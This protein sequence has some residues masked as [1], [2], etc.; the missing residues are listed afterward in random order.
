M[1]HQFA[2]IA[3]QDTDATLLLEALPGLLE[4]AGES[5]VAHMA[6][7]YYLIARGQS[8]PAMVAAGLRQVRASLISSE[9]D[10]TQDA[11][12]AD[13][14]YKLC[15]QALE[16]DTIPAITDL[17]PILQGLQI[18]DRPIILS[19]LMDALLD[20]I[21]AG[22]SLSAYE[23]VDASSDRLAYLAAS[24]EQLSQANRRFLLLGAADRPIVQV[25]VERWLTIAT[26]RMSDLQTQ[27]HIVC[28][29]VTR[30]ARE[31]DPIRLVLRLRNIGRATALNVR[32]SLTDST[33]YMGLNSGVTVDRLVVG[34]ETDVALSLRLQSMGIQKQFRAQ[35]IIHYD[36][37]R[38]SDQAERFADTVRIIAWQGRFEFIPNPYVVGTP[39]Q[40]GS[41][42]FFGRDDLF[43][44]IHESLSAAQRNNM[45]LIGQRRTGKS[46]L[47]K[48]L[49][50]RLG[51]EVVPI[52]LDGQG[53]ALDPGLSAFFFNVAMEMTYAL[54]DR[55]F[56][57]EVPE[58]DNFADVPAHV[59]ERQFLRQVRQAIGNR[60]L[61]LLLDEF[62]ELEVAVLRGSLDSS[63]FGYL[64]HLMQHGDNVSVIF[65]GTH[66][67]EELSADYWN[68]L[69]NISLYKQVGF[70][71]YLEAMRLIHEPVASYHMDYDDLAVDKMWRITAG[72]PYFL[73]LLCHS[74]VNVHNR[75]ERSYM[76]V[77]DVNT[78]LDDILST[79][80]AHFLHM[81]AES[82]PDERVLLAALSRMMPLTGYVTPAQAS[83][84]LAERG[85]HMS[86]QV[87]GQALRHLALRD[88]LF[89][90][91]SS[92]E[93]D[94][95]G[96]Y[97]WR[98]GLLG[99][100][101]ERYTSL[102]RVLEEKAK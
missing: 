11:V 93:I 41:P 101:V 18:Q 51:D 75:S 99:L 47:L 73:Q 46:S 7:A 42:L 92:D 61:L 67:L 57:I 86:R 79:G 49:P 29:L 84:Y 56:S 100:W 19:D 14:L 95:A 66:R 2:Q 63:V 85:V 20:L 25:I 12:E 54:E 55:G 6:E 36:D 37:P 80:E 34:E 82:T 39:L 15:Q 71:T 10:M 94:P 17:L 97:G 59:F 38:G 30:H 3:E 72:H 28:E 40:A 52:Y 96:A 4:L 43:A 81:W 70:L 45:V 23:R 48:Q 76:T 91:T 90:R 35:F 102:S 64:R 27:A 26:S 87:L 60:H 9:T 13:R 88:I 50:L 98:L 32:I 78:A 24:I 58:L 8:D 44:F 83:D 21:P 69:F 77:A 65:C 62:E 89:M 68:V 53:I 74:L 31:D 22:K 5:N 1:L 16:V 33:G